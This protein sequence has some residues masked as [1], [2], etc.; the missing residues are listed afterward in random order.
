MTL[1]TETKAL[2]TEAIDEAFEAWMTLFVLD[3][4][5]YTPVTFV[6]LRHSELC[7]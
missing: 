1:D 4:L 3:G 5:I 2:L 6:C 7:R